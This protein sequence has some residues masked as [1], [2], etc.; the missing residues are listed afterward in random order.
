VSFSI[1]SKIFVSP[2]STVEAKFKNS[3][4]SLATLSS[5]VSSCL[6]SSSFSTLSTTSVSP[7]LT[8]T[9][10]SITDSS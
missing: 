9:F 4:S 6:E 7:S 3:S 2:S 8:E 10:S 1:L 5:T